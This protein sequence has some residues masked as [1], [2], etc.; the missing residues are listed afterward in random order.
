MPMIG[1]FT[2]LTDEQKRHLGKEYFFLPIY[3]ILYSA[4]RWHYKQYCV[5]SPEEVWYY[6]TMFS[7]DLT[8]LTCPE[9]QADDEIESLGDYMDNSEAT[10]L[11]ALAA[12]YRLFPLTRRDSV[13][14]ES[15]TTLLN[16]YVK[17]HP[18]RDQMLNK[19]AYSE[20]DAKLQKYRVDIV[21]YQL[22][23]IRRHAADTPQMMFLAQQY[24]VSEQVNEAICQGIDTM[25]NYE[26]VLSAVNL[27]QNHIFDSQL[28]CLQEGIRAANRQQKPQ[29]YIFKIEKFVGAEVK[30]DKINKLL[31]EAITINSDGETP[32]IGSIKKMVVADTNI[33]HVDTNYQK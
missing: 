6:A 11:V 15:V 25:K 18:L 26:N 24:L 33:E 23:D 1:T 7:T 21:N 5:L 22:V 30:I 3:P 17:P 32:G 13:L 12:S 31:T 10:F 4:L 19:I 28:A 8:E 20:D 27:S 16:T 2:H 9:L 14:K 29:T